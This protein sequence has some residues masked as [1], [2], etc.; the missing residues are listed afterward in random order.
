MK[1]CEGFVKPGSEYLV[2]QLNKTL[3]GLHKAL[4]HGMKRSTSSSK[5]Y[6]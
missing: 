2:C 4:E 5:M 3:Y 1:Q 6:K